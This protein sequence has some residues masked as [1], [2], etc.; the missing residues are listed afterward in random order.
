MKVLIVED[1]EPARER[2]K[3]QVEALQQYQ[4]VAVAANGAEALRLY[5]RHR[6]EIVLLDI[7]MPLMDGIEA[8]RHLSGFDDPP[9]IIFTTA[10][11]EHMLEAFETGALDYLLK[12]VRRQR[13]Q[14]ALQKVSRLNRAQL[15]VLQESRHGAQARTHLCARERGSLVLVPVG[16]IYCLQADSKYVNVCYR[17]GELLIE[18]SLKSL[19][20]EFA[21]YF[22]RIHRATLVAKKYLLGLEKSPDGRT[23]VRVQGMDKGLE[24]SRRHLPTIRKLFKRAALK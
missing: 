7:R 8:A 22:V 3:S 4:V 9:A 12:P 16:D 18:E 13:L 1:E 19:E 24:V 10:Y 17:Q 6:P 2:L 15:K 5:A 23:L 14:K 21:Q 11:D 20:Q